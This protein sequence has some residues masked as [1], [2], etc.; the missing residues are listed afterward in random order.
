L[1]EVTESGKR[2]FVPLDR[3][4]T[5]HNTDKRG[6]YRWGND[7][8]LLAHL[9]GGGVTVRLYANAED[10]KRKFNRA[11][12]M[13]QTRCGCGGRTASGTVVSC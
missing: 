9:S 8:R 4:R 12:S 1:G 3:V 11:E 7:Y 13:R 5:H 6:T 10:A 2:V